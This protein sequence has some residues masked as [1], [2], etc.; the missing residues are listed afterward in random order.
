[1]ISI[2]DSEEPIWPRAPPS[3]ALTTSRRNI[4]ERLSSCCPE[5]CCAVSATSF[6]IRKPLEVSG[7]RVHPFPRSIK[8]TLLG[9]SP[10]C[11]L[12]GIDA[13]DPAFGQKLIE[14]DHA[15]AY[16]EQR[17]E[18]RQASGKGCIGPVNP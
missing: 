14:Q 7:Q 8:L 10:I 6:A 16:R 9:G 2:S 3:S 12:A 11:L 15:P 5:S 17:I 18:K 4:I 1:M 13:V